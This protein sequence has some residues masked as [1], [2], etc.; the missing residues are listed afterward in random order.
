MIWLL[1][2]IVLSVNIF[3]KEE[4][5]IN[6]KDLEINDFIKI[7]SKIINKNILITSKIKGKIDF[8]STKSVYKDDILNIL[9]YVLE[10]K[11]YTIIEN[12]GIL[13]IIRL[14]DAAKHNTPVYSNSKTLKTFQMI[15]EVFN[16]KY[17]NVDYISSKIRHLISKSAKLVTDK[18]SNSIVLTDF[19]ANI[20]TV[21]KVISLVSKNAKRDIQT[22]QLKNIKGAGIMADLKSV[23]KSVFN[24]KILSQKVF[25]LL[26]KDTNSIMFVGDKK[27]V[28]FL[29]N[30]LKEIEKKGSL[31]EKIV[32]VVSL[33][34]AE[35]KSV[36]KIISGIIAQKVYKDKNNKPFASTDEESNSIIL[37][38]P[39]E[40]IVYFK[41]LIEKLDIDRQQVYVQARIIEV[42]QSKLRNAGV[43]YGLN[44]FSA[45]TGGLATFSS[46][47]TGATTTGLTDISSLGGLDLSTMKKGLS[48][49]MTINLL[50]QNGA[51]DIVSEPSLL[52]INNKASS[53][54]VGETRS[55]EVGSTTTTTGTTKNYK[56]EDIGLTLKIKPRISTG[57]KVLLEISTKLEDADLTGGTNA[58]PNTSKKELET[59]AIV[60]NGESIIL[61]GYIKAKKESTIHKVP[62]LSD[63]PLLGSLFK[64]NYEATDKINLIIIITPYIIPK[65]KDL[66]YVRN[67]LIELRLLEEK[68]TKD[69]V[70][71]LEKAKL[72]SKKEDLIRE[73]ER[74]VLGENRRELKEDMI[75]FSEDKKDYT[76]N[77]KEELSEVLSTDEQL[78]N[79]RV[80]EMFGL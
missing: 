22:V 73:E 60:N 32:E 26:N 21:K 35:S 74:I 52:C 78:H 55:I 3:A 4:I 2:S 12:E 79:A 72:N 75:N 47:I 31:I 57:N 76:D 17:S 64:N 70:L 61:G 41:T 6:F 11:G 59:T 34:N 18:E 1:C 43:K 24:E 54:Y 15:T 29:V 80:K 53:I 44:G 56:R 63:I 16:V 42:S 58:Q 67:Q 66:T 5:N 7:T 30:Y 25:I 28:D 51:A 48:L 68:Y 69:T 38:G 8:I 37:M 13:R 20:K 45:G 33:K 49:G 65:T 10:S 39:K 46:A 9:I 19:A 36:L 14:N 62:I 71:R 23:A 27:N 40:Q 50:N 77:K